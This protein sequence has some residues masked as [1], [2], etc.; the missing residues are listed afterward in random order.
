MS[1]R[2]RRW[3]S[4]LRNVPVADRSGTEEPATDEPRS[5]RPRFGEAPLRC[6]SLATST[7]DGPP[8]GSLDP[9]DPPAPIIPLAPVGPAQIDDRID[10]GIAPV[11]RSASDRSST[12]G[13]LI[14]PAGTGCG[15]VG[16]R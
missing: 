8:V 6:T 11:R 16:T 15:A 4:E 9:L 14:G 5:D 3:R 2:N 12:A 7:V 10:C 1:Q 13:T